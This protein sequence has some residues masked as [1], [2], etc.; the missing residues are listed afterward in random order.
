MKKILIF[1]FFVFLVIILVE[2]RYYFNVKETKKKITKLKNTQIP[3]DFKII[4]QKKD[5]REGRSVVYKTSKPQLLNGYEGKNYLVGFFYGWENIFNSSDYYLLLKE[6]SKKSI[7]KIRV[8]FDFFKLPGGL[9]IKTSLALENLSKT[10]VVDRHQE[11]VKFVS[12]FSSLSWLKINSLIK[13]NDVLVIFP[14]YRK[15]QL[16]L[17]ENKQ[18]IGHRI[19]IRRYFEINL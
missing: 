16:V 5:D 8:L 13:E 2:I 14:L 7:K 10:K 19:V 1:F 15:S 6:P 3:S 11:A 9:E 17:D 12:Y 18:L 4:Y